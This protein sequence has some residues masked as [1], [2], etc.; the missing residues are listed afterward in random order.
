[1]KRSE[2]RDD[3]TY[4]LCPDKSCKLFFEPDCTI[5]CESECPKESEM[6]KL[7]LCSCG[8]IVVLD[9]DHFS[10]LRVDH[11]CANGN[12]ASNFC[13]MSGKYHLI[14]EVPE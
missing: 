5:P 12:T 4:I 14:Y 7:V 3:T 8:E 10:V 2:M 1:M 9:G 11:N 13:R 6:K